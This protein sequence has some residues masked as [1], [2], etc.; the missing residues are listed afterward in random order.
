MAA[1]INDLLDTTAIYDYNIILQKSKKCK[2]VYLWLW[3]LIMVNGGKVPFGSLDVP[4][5][6]QLV[7]TNGNGWRW[8]GKRKG[9]RENPKSF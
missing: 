9:P 5:K 2:G 7:T 8:R 3:D 4:V 1:K 6:F